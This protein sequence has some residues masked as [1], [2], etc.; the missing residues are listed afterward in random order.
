MGKS[1]S[2]NSCKTKKMCY[3]DRKDGGMSDTKIQWYPSFVAA[4]NLELKE[5]KN[6]LIYE[7]EYNLIRRGEEA[8]YE[9]TAGK[10]KQ[11]YTSI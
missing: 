2:D 6:D 5:N 11:P 4:M 7:K 9:G 3:N 1:M 10:D 8:G